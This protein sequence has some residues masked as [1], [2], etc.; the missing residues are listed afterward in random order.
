MN[1]HLGYV[2]RRHHIH[3]GPG[4]IG[5]QNLADVYGGGHHDAFQRADNVKNFLLQGCQLR[6]LAAHG[7]RVPP[8]TR[9]VVVTMRVGAVTSLRA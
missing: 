9:T 5:Q 7:G 1:L 3:A 2:L 6:D 8:V 4:C